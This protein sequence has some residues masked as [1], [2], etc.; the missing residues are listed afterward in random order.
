[1][2]QILVSE[3][4]YITPELKRKKNIYKFN[5]IVSIV[6]IVVLCLFYARSEYA[7]SKEEEISQEIFEQ[8]VEEAEKSS[9]EEKKKKK[10]DEGVWKIMIASTRQ[11]DQN[12]Q[13]TVSQEQNNNQQIQ[14]NNQIQNN[15]QQTTNNAQVQTKVEVGNKVKKRTTT[16]TVNGTRYKSLGRIKIPKINV[17]QVILDEPKNDDQMV[18]WLKI[19]PVK[20]YGADPNEIGNCSIAGHN[21]RNKRFFSKV[22]TLGIGDKIIITD[23]S[24]KT[25]TYS[26]F[27]KYTVDPK[28]TDCVYK[29]IPGKRI[30]T[31]ITCTDD[32]KKRVIIHA[33]EV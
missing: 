7:K 19:S 3:K 29:E 22:P 13:Q 28:N 31:L 6:I 1:M 30:V 16:Y 2:N 8:M 21:Y 33:K 26:I 20:F 32:T 10:K 5:L 9:E 4:L 18:K 14:N 11:Q 17:D 24:N 27:D 12:T 23:V 15:Q 25:I